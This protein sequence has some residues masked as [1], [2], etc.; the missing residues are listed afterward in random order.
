MVFT[1]GRLKLR[2]QQHNDH[3][4][5][6]VKSPLTFSE[7]IAYDR[8]DQEG[9]KQSTFSKVVVQDPESLEQ[10]LATSCGLKG[11]VEKMRYLFMVDRTRIHLDSRVVFLSWRLC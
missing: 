3:E 1:A 10:V 8:S 6:E 11:V 4:K 7:L 9:P 5:V 2:Q